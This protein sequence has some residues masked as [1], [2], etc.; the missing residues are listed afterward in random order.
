[1]FKVNNEDTRTTSYFTPLSI[2]SVVDIEQ[3]NVCWELSSSVSNGILKICKQRVH[4]ALNTI[5][6]HLDIINSIRNKLVLI[7]NSIKSFSCLSYSRVKAR[8]GAGSKDFT[9]TGHVVPY[10][11]VLSSKLIGRDIFV[12]NA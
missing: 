6:G 5:I 3:V 12:F 7:E 1:M 2:V 4:N 9:L 10:F 8:F 11:P